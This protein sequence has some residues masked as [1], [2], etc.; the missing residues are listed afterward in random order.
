MFLIN[1][2]DTLH[3]RLIGS[4][5][6]TM[7][8]FPMSVTYSDRLRVAC[9]LNG[10]A[11]NGVACFSVDQSLGLQPQGPLRPLSK[12]NNTT[13]PFGPPGSS[14]QIQFNPSSSAVF[15]TIKGAPPPADSGY[16]YAFPVDRG[17]NVGTTPV[18]S[19]PPQSVLEFSINFLGDDS[20][21]LVTDPGFG[22]SIMTIASDFTVTE[23]D[24]IVIPREV[25]TCWGAYYP[26]Y[27]SAYVIDGAQPNI[28][29]VD[30]LSGTIK[31]AIQF[32]ADAIGGFDTIIH[33]KFMYLLTGDSSVLVIDLS[34]GLGSVIQK[35]S[36]AQEG[37]AGEWQG[38]AAWPN[39]R[40]EAPWESA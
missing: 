23:K 40:G 39:P 35:Y 31:G 22:A 15:V 1:P 30:S 21:A 7:G 14:S 8:E 33:K 29:V 38:M 2:F 6:D 10:G 20:S 4:P 12:L 28:T 26:R 5:V 17:G 19:H 13:P 3:P 24:H 16:I 27:Q 34:E 11:K 9:V 37:P 32:E 36:L 18:V 25:A